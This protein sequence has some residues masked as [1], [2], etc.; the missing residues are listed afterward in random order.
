MELKLR[1]ESPKNCDPISWQDEDRSRCELI[2]GLANVLL[3]HRLAAI[4]TTGPA[5]IAL[6]AGII[7]I[8]AC[9]DPFLGVMNVSAGVLRAAGDIVYVTVTAFIGLWVFRIAISLLLVHVFKMGIYG[10]MVG[11]SMDFVVRAAMYGL[12]VK[13]GRWKQLKV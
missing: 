9:I 13:A 4:F 1:L 5:V 6:S 8:F 11:V 7:T 12:R 2:L 10:V 3:A